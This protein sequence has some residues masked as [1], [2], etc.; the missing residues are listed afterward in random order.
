MIHEHR[1]RNKPLV[2]PGVAQTHTNIHTFRHTHSFLTVLWDVIY[3]LY[4]LFGE[5]QPHCGIKDY[6]LQCLGYHM[7]YR[8]LNVGWLCTRQ[9]IKNLYHLFIL[10]LLLVFGPCLAGF[11]VHFC[12]CSGITLGRVWTSLDWLSARLTTYMLYYSSNPQINCF[13]FT[14]L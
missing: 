4:N 9:T 10:N 2:L 11:W 7:C 14:V 8:I 6:F 1:I 3:I 5:F 12:F 13:F